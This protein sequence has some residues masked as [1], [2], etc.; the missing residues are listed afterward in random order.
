MRTPSFH[1][2]VLCVDSN[3]TS[4]LQTPDNVLHSL[5]SNGEL[6]TAPRL[7]HSRHRI[8]A[9]DVSIDVRAVDASR[10][11]GIVPQRAFFIDVEGEFDAL[12]TFRLPLVAHLRAQEISTIYIL[13]DEVSEEIAKQI[14]PLI[15]KI[16][17]RL[18]GY[19]MKF[20]VTKFGPDWWN[21]TADADM[22]KKAHDRKQ[23]ERVFSKYIDNKPYLIDFG[24]IGKVIYAQSS[25]FLEKEHII[26][27]VM[28][29]DA[30]AE[31]VSALKKDLQ[32]NYTKFF[33]E[34]FKDN[35][36]QDK[37][38]QL[39]AIRHKVAHNNLFIKEDLN[40]ARG[41]CETLS[42]IVDTAE[43]KID[44]VVFSKDEKIAVEEIITERLTESIHDNQEYPYW[45]IPEALLLSELEQEQEFA[46]LRGGYVGLSRFVTDH[47]GPK[48]YDY[49]A[50]FAIIN[51]LVTK[52]ILEIYDVMTD[53]GYLAKAVRRIKGP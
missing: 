28:S 43:A 26:E 14:Y 22:R 30:T 24:E 7:D 10:E 40:A 33:K 49:A 18:R 37:W 1:F 2:E 21:V 6:L 35:D 38:T 5:A 46:K 25:G 3:E 39:A 44:E 27:R 52:G 42:S 50:S 12:E 8:D 19:L 16:E 51:D 13:L 20:F 53:G 15:N 45:P 47:L 34:T 41:I 48:K 36:F 4:K 31:A 11:A 9:D 17:N 32:S 23:N 29:V